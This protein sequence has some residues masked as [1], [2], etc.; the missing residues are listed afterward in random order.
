MKFKTQYL[1]AHNLPI[2]VSK[3]NTRLS[4]NFCIVTTC[5]VMPMYEITIFKSFAN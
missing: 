2:L 5:K 3:T 1:K 4:R